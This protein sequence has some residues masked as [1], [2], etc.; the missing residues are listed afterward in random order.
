MAAERALGGLWE[1]RLQ[2][3]FLEAGPVLLHAVNWTYWLAQALVVAFA[4]VWLYLRH[5]RVYFPM[6]NAL[7]VANT[8]GL[9]V[10]VGFPTAPPR[11]FPEDGFVD[12]LAR[13]E[14]LNHGSSLVEI[15]SN[16]Y[17]AMPS[18][19]A[20]DAAIAGV[21]LALAVRPPLLRVL[22]LVWP[23]WVSFALIA[24]AN[25]FWLDIAAGLALAALGAWIAT[26]PRSARR[27]S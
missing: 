12:T 1:P 15:F 27:F 25:H 4:L 24:S 22:C 18:L 13:A 14:A 19:H 20:A 5:T 26:R 23:L 21:A 8:I 3:R 11:L 16:P 2:H 7:I 10:Y 9:A 17:A 6:R